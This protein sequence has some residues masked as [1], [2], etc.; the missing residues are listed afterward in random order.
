MIRIGF[1]ENTHT[2]G[3]VIRGCK[4]TQ[5]MISTAELLIIAKG[6]KPP[7]CLLETELLDCDMFTQYY[8]NHTVNIQNEL[9]L[10]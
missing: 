6:W 10:M 9:C 8:T 4:Q 1:T 2:Q 7:Q 3:W 5:E